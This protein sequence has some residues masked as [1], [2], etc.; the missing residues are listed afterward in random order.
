MQEKLIWMQANLTWQYAGRL[1]S[2]RR[3]WTIASGNRVACVREVPERC[4]FTLAP[5]FEMDYRGDSGGWRFGA[6]SDART[7]FALGLER[8]ERGW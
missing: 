5:L 6:R 8:V 1:H 2:G 4:P 3:V 7:I